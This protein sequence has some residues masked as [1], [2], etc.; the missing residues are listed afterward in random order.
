MQ[1]RNSFLSKNNIKVACCKVRVELTCGRSDWTESPALTPAP[2][3]SAGLRK[4][5]IRIHLKD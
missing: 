2:A 3:R 5:K 1:G 4:F